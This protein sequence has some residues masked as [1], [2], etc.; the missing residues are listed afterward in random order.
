MRTV[1]V[2]ILDVIALVNVIHTNGTFLAFR[3]FLMLYD[4]EAIPLPYLPFS[5]EKTLH[6][7]GKPR[8]PNS[9][10][11][12]LDLVRRVFVVSSVDG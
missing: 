12:I 9:T 2:P 3:W 11:S 7:G 10:T 5:A 8:N 4:S 1:A 6:N